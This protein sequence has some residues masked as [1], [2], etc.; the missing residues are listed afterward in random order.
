[1]TDY[2]PLK[3]VNPTESENFIE[4]EK[5]Y[6]DAPNSGTP[7]TELPQI[8]DSWDNDE[9]EDLK[10]RVIREELLDARCEYKVW[11][12]Q[13]STASE[14]DLQAGGNASEDNLPVSISFGAEMV[15]WTPP[16]QFQSNFLWKDASG[17]FTA[18][19]NTSINTNINRRI[20][21]ITYTFTRR[22]TDLPSF[23][24]ANL[25]NIN[26]INSS[27]FYGI[28]R[29]YLLYTGAD[30]DSQIGVNG[31]YWIARLNMIQR[32]TSPERAFDSNGNLVADV[33]GWN[34][35]LRESDG[36]FSRPYFTVSSGYLYQ[37]SDFK[38]LITSGYGIYQP[39]TIN[40][41]GT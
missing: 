25:R 8:G 20:V 41:I 23:K 24:V 7:I 38:N 29:G 16:K 36:Q 6:T 4:G 27:T 17:S 21:L 19:N 15:S 34:Y 33:D 2:Y 5:R 14:D 18:L 40:N 26:R 22:V 11:V 3:F 10:L 13:Y 1:M 9:Y 12:L 37:Y 31:K 28:P 30:M 32:F 39:Q 35:C